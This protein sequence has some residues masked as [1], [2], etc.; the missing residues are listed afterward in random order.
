M[1]RSFLFGAL[2]FSGFLTAEA[3]SWRINNNA[4][5]NADFTTFNAAVNATGVQ[6]GDTIYLEPSAVEYGTGSI[7]VTKRLTVI[8]AGYLLDPS[9]GTYPGNPGL[10]LHTYD[11]RLAFFRLG[12][13]ASGSKFL[14]VTI[15]GSVYMN[16]ASNITFER[17]LFGGGLYFENGTNNNT[18]VR[19]CYLNGAA[20]SSS[21]NATV[22]G[23][24]CENS[25]F[26]SNAHINLPNLTGSDNIVRNNSITNASNSFALVNT[27]FVNNIVGTFSQNS[28]TNCT[29]KNNFFQVNQALP[30]TATNNQVSVNMADIYA[31]TGSFD[32]RFVL[33]TSAAAIG[34]GLTVGSV[35][36]PDC[37]AFGGTDPYKLSGIP[38]IPTIYQLTVPVSI[39][40]GS[41]TMNIT[42]SA[43]NNN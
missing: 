22:S 32:G 33:K 6:D 38:N 1:K 25:I 11:T 36:S 13:A 5:V 17:C 24:V 27:Y 2:L 7:S 16:G 42:F 35:V 8:A 14:G 29:I 28:L 26:N 10:Q 3:R 39:P 21:V 40:S 37:G 31:G 4:G 43:R 34:A 41:A 12:S 23:F 9:N 18:T 19:K 15:S 30:G 20:I